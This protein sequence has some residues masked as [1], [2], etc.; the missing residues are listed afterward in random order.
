MSTKIEIIERG[1]NIVNKIIGTQSI[2]MHRVY[3]LSQAQSNLDLSLP[4]HLHDVWVVHSHLTLTYYFGVPPQNIHPDQVQMRVLLHIQ[5][6]E[7]L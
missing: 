2:I 6:R 4:F 3:L 7:D 5:H 1:A